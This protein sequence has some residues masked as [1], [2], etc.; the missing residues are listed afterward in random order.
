MGDAATGRPWTNPSRVTL[1]WSTTGRMS[2]PFVMLVVKR[3]RRLPRVLTRPDARTH[4]ARRWVP[5][6]PC[7]ESQL[8]RGVRAT[9]TPPRVAMASAYAGP[10]PRRGRR[11]GRPRR[12]RRRPGCP[13]HRFELGRRAAGEVDVGVFAGEGAGGRFPPF[14]PFLLGKLVP[15]LGSCIARHQRGSRSL[16]A[17][18][19]PLESFGEAGDQGAHGQ[20]ER[21]DELIVPWQWR[22]CHVAGARLHRGHAVTSR[23]TKVVAATAAATSM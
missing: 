12:C 4:R 20:A 11:G 9:S 13:G 7:R 17:A 3:F 16:Y 21:E 23:R 6:S 2:G 5:S 22:R 14:R 15:R 10:P 18:V 19:A 8:A 1:I